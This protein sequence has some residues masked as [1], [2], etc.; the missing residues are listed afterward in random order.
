MRRRLGIHPHYSLFT[1]HYSL[2]T[3]HTYHYSL[4]TIRY[5]LFAH[6][7][8]YAPYFSTQSA[9]FATSEF[10]PQGMIG[11][12]EVEFFGEP[13]ISRSEYTM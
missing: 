12:D 5:S 10:A 2:F 3:I 13:S 1:I 11:T 7:L 8:F 4:F 6:S 9:H